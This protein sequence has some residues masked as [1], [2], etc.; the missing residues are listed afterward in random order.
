MINKNVF[1]F[2]KSLFPNLIKNIYYVFTS[3]IFPT[4]KAFRLLLPFFFFSR[5]ESASGLGRE[6]DNFKTLQEQ[7]RAQQGTQSHHPSIMT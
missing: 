2:A 3:S 5:R 7:N 4:D 1:I 6:G